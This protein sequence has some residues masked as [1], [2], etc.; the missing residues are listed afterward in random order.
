MNVILN[1][2]NSNGYKEEKTHQYVIK[3]WD[4]V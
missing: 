4:P 3:K 1:E 2:G